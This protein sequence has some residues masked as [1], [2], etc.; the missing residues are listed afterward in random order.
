[1]DDVAALPVMWRPR[2]ATSCSTSGPMERNA[3][4]QGP[5][6]LHF[7]AQPKP[8]RSHLPVYPCLIDRG[9]IMHRTYPTKCAYVEPKCG[10]V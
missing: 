4:S 1:M 2:A 6:L 10:R 7:S 5:T 9:E 8:F 3:W